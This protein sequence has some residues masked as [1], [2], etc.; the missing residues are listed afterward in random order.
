[1]RA[2]H[3][4]RGRLASRRSGAARL[5]ARRRAE[6]LSAAGAGRAGDRQRATASANPPAPPV[7]LTPLTAADPAT[8]DEVLWHIA[9][10]VPHLRRWLVANPAADA[11]LLEY[12][13]QVGG[14]GVNEA[15][16]I[17]LES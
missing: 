6:T 1:M 13:A 12:V 8:A 16:T 3:A 14:P 11:A 2:R 9:R 5:H 10:E 7:A 17:L 15:L 4:R